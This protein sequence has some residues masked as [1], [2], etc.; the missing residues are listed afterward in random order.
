MKSYDLVVYIGLVAYASGL[1][2]KSDHSIEIFKNTPKKGDHLK[3]GTLNLIK[4]MS[5][6]MTPFDSGV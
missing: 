5:K 1:M 2:S 4:W 6:A 3:P